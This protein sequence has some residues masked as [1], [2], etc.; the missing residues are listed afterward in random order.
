[1]ASEKS[2]PA[3]DVRIGGFRVTWQR[4]PVRLVA[5]LTTGVGSALT[6][7]WTSR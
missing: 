2:T 1:M 6:A 4:V 3:V 7:W 5:F